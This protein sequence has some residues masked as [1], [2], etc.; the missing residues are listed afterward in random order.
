LNEVN[1]VFN[2]VHAYTLTRAN[3]DVLDLSQGVDL[4]DAVTVCSLWSL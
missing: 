2:Y 1:F 4:I 3:H